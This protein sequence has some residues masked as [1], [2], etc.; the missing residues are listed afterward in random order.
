M[1]GMRKQKG[2]E[3]RNEHGSVDGLISKT[4]ATG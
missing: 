1:V 2:R 4:V 3:K